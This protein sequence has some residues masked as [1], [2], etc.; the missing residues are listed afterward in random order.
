MAKMLLKIIKVWVPL[1]IIISLFSGLVYGAVQQGLRQS[2]YDPQIQISEDTASVLSSGKNPNEIISADK[3]DISKSL[4]SYIIIFDKDGQPTTSSAQ[5]DGRIPLPPKGVFAY[6][7]SH[8][9]DR[10]TWQPKPGVRSAVVVT[11]FS[12][13]QT[14]G[15]VLAGRSMRELEIREE[16]ILKDVV[17]GGSFIVLLALIFTLL[18]A[19]YHTKN[20]H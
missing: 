8:H 16:M 5:L 3:V 6:T 1:A 4:A 13:G 7:Q 2:A 20:V 15:Y 17:I 11:Y 14:S 12:N 9:Q 18:F 10:F 19:K